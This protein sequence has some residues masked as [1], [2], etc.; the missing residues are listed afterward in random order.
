MT[1]PAPSLSVK[2]SADA[3]S[4][5]PGATITVD[6]SAL[7]ALAVAA[8]VSASLAG[9]TVNA[10]VDFTVEEAA[11]AATFGISDSTNGAISWTMAPG[12]GPG[13]AVFTG[14]APSGLAAPAA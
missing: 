14:T 6:A 7:Q 1:T 8:T 11:T 2:A 3:P 9:V 12:A 10:E 13:T 5:A 4:Y